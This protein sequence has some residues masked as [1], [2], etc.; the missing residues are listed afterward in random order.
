VNTLTELKGIEK[1]RISIEGTTPDDK[2]C[3][4]IEDW[5]QPLERDETLV[6]D[7]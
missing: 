3:G 1:L 7:D 5:S 6:A 4:G 2:D